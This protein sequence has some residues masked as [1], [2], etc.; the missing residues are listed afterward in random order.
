[1]RLSDV[2]S[3]NVAAEIKLSEMRTRNWVLAGLVV[4]MVG[5]IPAIFFL[6]SMYRDISES[7]KD[8]D[9]LS[10]RVSTLERL[11]IN[12]LRGQK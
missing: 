10:E 1:M 7:I 2:V 9:K 8:Q 12:Q 6:G 5:W 3:E 4:N 11:E